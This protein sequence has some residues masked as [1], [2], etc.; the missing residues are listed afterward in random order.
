LRISTRYKP[1]AKAAVVSAV[2]R[3][4]GKPNR[5]LGLIAIV[6]FRAAKHASAFLRARDDPPARVIADNYE[7]IL[8]ANGPAA[9]LGGE[10]I[11]SSSVHREFVHRPA[12]PPSQAASY[13]NTLS[14]LIDRIV[15]ILRGIPDLNFSR[16]VGGDTQAP[17]PLGD[18]ILEISATHFHNG[19]GDSTLFGCA[20]TNPAQPGASYTDTITKPDK[21][22]VSISG[23]L[24]A[25]GKATISTPINQYGDYTQTLA[26]TSRAKKVTKTVTSSVTATQGQNGCA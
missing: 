25:A 9:P 14:G 15:K 18:Y 23:V 6:N 8:E 12:I 2:L 17:P 19:P 16:A 4:R 24:D 21:S 5:Y 20:R 22:T 26:V 7:F 3:V 13:G 1:P 11:G 10:W